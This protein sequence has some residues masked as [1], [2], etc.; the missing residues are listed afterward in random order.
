ME[1]N[2][3]ALQWE[4]AARRL[5]HLIA[6]GKLASAAHLIKACYQNGTFDKPQEWRTAA[7]LFKDIREIKP[8]KRVIK[9]HKGG[10][11]ERKEFLFTPDELTL[12]LEGA[13]QDGIS[14][15]D[16]VVKAIRGVK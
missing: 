13:K 1:I 9:A 3:E 14:P 11:T 2:Q 16:Y 12:I 4:L 6:G 7:L 15:T 5:G 8:K 10:R